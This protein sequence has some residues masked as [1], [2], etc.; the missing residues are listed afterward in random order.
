MMNY[1]NDLITRIRNGL[2]EL[3]FHDGNVEPVLIDRLQI[4]LGEKQHDYKSVFYNI[5][6]YGISNITVTNVM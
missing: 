1:S 6:A 5:K 2:P 3:G 4:R